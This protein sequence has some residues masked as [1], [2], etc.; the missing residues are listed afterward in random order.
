[1]DHRRPPVVVLDRQRQ[2]LVADRVAVPGRPAV[3]AGDHRHPLGSQGEQLRGLARL[4]AYHLDVAV[5]VQQQ[6]R[7]E[8]LEQRLPGAGRLHQRQRPGVRRRQRR[9]ADPFGHQPDRALRHRVVDERAPHRLA[10]L[11]RRR[12]ERVGP[13]RSE[14]ARQ[15][16]AGPAPAL[17]GGGERRQERHG[18]RLS[19]LALAA[20]GEDRSATDSSRDARRS[21]P[22][23][24]K[25]PSEARRMGPSSEA[26]HQA[27]EQPGLPLYGR[28][29]RAADRA[30]LWGRPAR[31]GPSPRESLA[32]ARPA[33][34]RPSL[35][36]RGR[37]PCRGARRSRPRGG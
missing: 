5:A 3:L 32:T 23:T 7:G 28:G 26:P 31:P 17:E 6:L 18:M 29:A 14:A 4:I 37:G 12:L 1:V 27:A 24:G 13:R 22:F 25:V 34:R 21:S 16:H 2:R 30:G 20:H 33:P 8:R 15:R 9:A 10:V 36:A 19:G 11:E 35:P